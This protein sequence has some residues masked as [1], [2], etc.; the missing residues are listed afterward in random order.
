MKMNPWS[1]GILVGVVLS[2]RYE[3]ESPLTGLGLRLHYDSSRLRYQ[4]LRDVLQTGLLS[5]N[6]V[7]QADKDDGDGDPRTDKIWLLAWVDLMSG[8]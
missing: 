6:V 3:A 2:V 7:P 5:S 1:S 4:G 8:Q